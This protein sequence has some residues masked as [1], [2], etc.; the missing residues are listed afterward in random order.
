MCQISTFFDIIP[1]RIVSKT[2]AQFC[3]I[4]GKKIGTVE[5]IG[6]TRDIH[7]FSRKTT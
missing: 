4:F 1:F 2:Y 6:W 7:E 3:N 5:A